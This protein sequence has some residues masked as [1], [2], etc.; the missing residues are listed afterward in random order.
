MARTPIAVAGVD[1]GGSEATS[2]AGDPIAG[3]QMVNNGQSILL[4]RNANSATTARTLA[5]RLPNL[6]DGQDVVPKTWTIPAGEGRYLG[7]FPTS[8]YSR[9]L[10][11]DPDHGDLR[12]TALQRGTEIDVSAARPYD[13]VIL[14][15]EPE[16]YWTLDGT[17]AGL[18]DQ[19]SNGRNA[20]AYGSPTASTG[21]DGSGAFT[22]NGTNQYIDAGDHAAFSAATTGI[23]TVEVWM[24]PAVLTFPVSQGGGDYIHWMGK[25]TAGQSEYVARMYNFAPA[26][27]PLRPNRVSGYAFNLSGGLGTGSYF[28]DVWSVGTWMHYVLII[29]TVDTSAAYPTGYVELWKNG[30]LRDKDRLADF[31]IV[32]ANGTAPLRFATSS[33]D[34]FLQGRLQ[35]AAVY[36]YA[37]N[38][39]QIHTHYRAAVPLEVGSGDLTGNVGTVARHSSGDRIQIVVGEA[40]VPAGSMLLARAVHPYTAAG[41]TVVDSRGNTWTRDRTAA[42]G[43]TNIRASLFS[44]PVQV[45]LRPGDLIELRASTAVAALAF[46]VDAFDHVQ[47]TPVHA[48][49]G[50]SGSSTTPGTTLLVTAAVTDIV[51]YG[52]LGVAGP[53]ADTVTDDIAN[54]M[55]A[56]DRVGTNTGSGD[57]TLN[58]AWK[59]IEDGGV[60][61][62]L[63]VLGTSRPWVEIVG[64]Y[65]NGV[66]VIDPPAQGTAQRVANLTS[67]TSTSAGTTLVLTI[68]GPD[69]VPVGHTL[70]LTV[71]ADYTAA[72]AAVADSR[73]NVWTRDRT[74]AATGNAC[75]G[76]VFSCP[77]STALQP[78]DTVTITWGV[79]VTR[80]AA[81]ITQFTGPLI[82]TVVDA[83]TGVAGATGNPSTPLTSVTTNTLLFAATAMAGPADASYTPDATWSPLPTAGTTGATSS[84]RTIYPAFRVVSPAGAYPYS[85]QLQGSYAYVALLVAYRAG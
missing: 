36:N 75:R 51:V 8:W 14:A 34:S 76:A 38:A 28:Q 70:I 81:T 46:A 3:N 74:S 37:L 41:P 42:D 48:T 10:L 2:V 40:G 72:G 27:E 71:N 80:K 9:T 52:A 13:S 15:D 55:V 45:A 17:A 69:P 49:N 25:S 7:P 66:P 31:S 61:H 84:D 20:T 19:T 44:C 82:P 1:T 43:G 56:L 24:S 50:T 85:P 47:F 64:I 22:F 53:T 26:I 77:V 12:L 59:S 54:E 57:V 5:I 23:L 18:V 83:Q 73:S 33:L 63:P 35:R 60:Q 79:S 65:V 16:S 4:V 11:I 62:W 78:G 6:V 29:N 67:A 21:P 32:P 68:P 58:G 30:Q 39:S